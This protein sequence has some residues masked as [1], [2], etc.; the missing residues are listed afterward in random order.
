MWTERCGSVTFGCGLASRCRRR[1]VSSW[2]G[3]RPG[4]GIGPRR[5]DG[6]G[7]ARRVR[8]ARRSG[9]D[10]E[11]RRGRRRVPGER[12]E[13]DVPGGLEDLDVVEHRGVGVVGEVPYEGVAGVRADLGDDG[14]DLAV[15]PAQEVRE[16]P[17][18][19]RAVRR[20]QRGQPAALLRVG[21]VRQVQPEPGGDVADAGVQ[22]GVALDEVRAGRPYGLG[23]AAFLGLL[24]RGQFPQPGQSDLGDELPVQPGQRTE[25]RRHGLGVQGV[26]TGAGAVRVRPD[27]E[28]QRDEGR[29]EGGDDESCPT[30]RSGAVDGS[31]G[32]SSC[33]TARWCASGAGW[34]ITAGTTPTSVREERVDER[35]KWR[36]TGQVEQGADRCKTSQTRRVVRSAGVRC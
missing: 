31:H 27:R 10:G 5:G 35:E 20:L 16:L 13:V 7:G 24:T 28:D 12:V 21:L 18:V 32:A 33:G 9:R 25:P 14:E 15:S 23:G 22:E 26:Q 3:R 36:R 2:R 1:R 11:R 34:H 19:V 29:R 8:G 17:V 6:D 30:D 4:E